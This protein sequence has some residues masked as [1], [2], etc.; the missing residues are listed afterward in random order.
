MEGIRT[1]AKDNSI[2]IHLHKTF[3]E[4][5]AIKNAAFSFSNSCYVF[6]KPYD[7]EENLVRFEPKEGVEVDL[8]SVAKE[9][10]NSVLDHQ[11]RLDLEKMNS[12]IRNL[13]VKQAFSPIEKLVVGD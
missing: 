1:L 12:K 13:I 9:F 5:E 6:L 4:A 10:C 7:M 2:Q 11:I 8:E 3:Y